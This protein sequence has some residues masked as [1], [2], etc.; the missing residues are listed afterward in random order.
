MYATVRNLSEGSVFVR[1]ERGE[2]T[3]DLGFPP[4]VR[5]RSQLLTPSICR[6]KTSL[7]G[8]G[9]YAGRAQ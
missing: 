5:P 4:K 1:T 2:Q 8:G 7:L 9:Q 6:I 3:I